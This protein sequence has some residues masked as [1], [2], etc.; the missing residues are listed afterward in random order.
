MM[1]VLVSYAAVVPGAAALLY[2]RTGRVR[3]IDFVAA[4]LIVWAVKMVVTVGLYHALVTGDRNQYH[5]PAAP[6]TTGAVSHYRGIAD[7]AGRTLS[8]RVLGPDGRGLAGVAVSVEGIDEGAA[9]GVPARV[10]LRYENERL[11]PLLATAV[12]G[13]RLE[14]R[15]AS[16]QTV[17]LVGTSEGKTLF[18]VPVL[19]TSVRSVVLRRAGMVDVHGRIGAAAVGTRIVVSE[20]PY[21]A[22]TDEDGRFHLAHASTRGQELVLTAIDPELGVRRAKVEAGRDDVNLDLDLARLPLSS[23][24][25][26]GS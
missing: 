17:V 26:E 15:N 18:N 11:E 25:R 12:V 21:L 5:P 2:W 6:T 16:Q 13:S 14:I 10:D 24:S 7:Y 9:L 19:P 1:R 8:G 23:A 20:N 4:V 3:V 22:L